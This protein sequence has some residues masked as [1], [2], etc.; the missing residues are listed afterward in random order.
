MQQI[1]PPKTRRQLRRFLGMVNYRRDMW[2]RRSEVP[3]PL[4][5][6]SSD[7]TPWV[8]TD[9]C[10]KAFHTIKRILSKE[11][12]LSCPNFSLPFDIHTDASDVQLGAVIS[13]NDKPIAFSTRS[14]IQL[15]P[16]AQ[17]LKGN[18]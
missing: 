4:A 11:V 18:S 16:V 15:K 8:W 10:N 12:L 17:Q 14:L 13:Q 2:V 6:L 1:A 3:A 9:A 7:K 5:A